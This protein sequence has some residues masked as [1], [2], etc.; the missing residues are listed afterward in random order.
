MGPDF[1]VRQS[2][3]SPVPRPTH[4][5]SISLLSPHRHCSGA[6]T[7]TAIDLI[8]FLPFH[9]MLFLFLRTSSVCFQL[10]QSL[11]KYAPTTFSFS[12]VRDVKVTYTSRTT[13][14][15]VMDVLGHVPL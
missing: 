6:F 5:E 11:L 13:A 9:K 14:I 8:L 15:A 7:C 2:G 12:Q 10:L 4:H 3:D 1:T